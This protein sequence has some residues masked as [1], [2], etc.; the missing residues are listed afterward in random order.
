MHNKSPLP[1]QQRASMYEK[2][3]M[4][5]LSPESTPF[6]LYKETTFLEDAHDII[7]IHENARTRK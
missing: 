6:I 4:I 1:W 7:S 3:G 2:R 5:R